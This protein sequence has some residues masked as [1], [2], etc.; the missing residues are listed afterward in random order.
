MRSNRGVVSEARADRDV[1]HANGPR[2]APKR[3][4]AASVAGRKRCPQG[5]PDRCAYTR[6]DACSHALPLRTASHERR[7][8]H[9]RQDPQSPDN[10]LA[11]PRGEEG[12]SGQPVVGEPRP[13]HRPNRRTSDNQQQ[14][15]SLR[16]QITTVPVPPPSRAIGQISVGQHVKRPYADRNPDCTAQKG[17]AEPRRAVRGGRSREKQTSTQPGA[18]PPI[19]RSGGHARACP[20]LLHGT[21]GQRLHGRTVERQGRAHRLSQNRNRRPRPDNEQKNERMRQ[22][23][24]RAGPVRSAN[25]GTDRTKGHDL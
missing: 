21:P 18:H 20:P 25:R 16:P 23:Y 12:L 9:A 13:E 4:C 2:P 7:P 1:W 11:K 6:P 22:S 19:F 5:G 3:Q 10:E 14:R 15:G 24:E 17:A 8:S